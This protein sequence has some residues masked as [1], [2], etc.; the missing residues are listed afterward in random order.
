VMKIR[1]SLLVFTT[2]SLVLISSCTLEL[3]QETDPVVIAD[4]TDGPSNDLA[5]ISE[6]TIN[7]IPVDLG[8]IGISIDTRT[9][10]VF[11]YKPTKVNLVIE[12]ALGDYSQEGI[13]VDEY[14]NIAN[15]KLLR[16]DLSDEDFDEFSSGVPIIITVLDDTGAVIENKDV[17]RFIINSTARTIK[18][19][20]EKPRILRPLSF[21][22]AVPYYVQVVSDTELKFLSLTPEGGDQYYCPEPENYETKCIPGGTYGGGSYGSGTLDLYNRSVTVGRAFGFSEAQFYFEKTSTHD[23]DSS[24]YIKSK[25]TQAY[26]FTSEFN[27][28]DETYLEWTADNSIFLKTQ[29]ILEQTQNGTIKIR[30]LGSEQYLRDNEGDKRPTFSATSSNDLEFNIISANISWE[31]TD[32]GTKYSQPILPPV[33]MDFAFAQTIL[34]CSGATGDYEVGV[35]TVRETRTDISFGESLNLFS[36]ETSS[37]SATVKAEASGSLFGAGVTASVEGTLSTERTSTF[38]TTKERT[39]EEVFISKQ[40]V[41]IGRNITVPPYNAVEVFDVIQTLENIQI[42]FVQRIIIRGVVDEINL[43]GPEI[44]AQLIANGFGG[45][46]TEIGTDFLAVSVRGTIKVANYFE[47]NN[48]LNDI[49]GGCN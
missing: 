24:Y 34:N 20:T 31:F 26:L 22:A 21:N 15:F 14:T 46:I 29:F 9:L 12:G 43:T 33:E 2:I 6:E 19:T 13:N 16:K 23:Q 39:K 18:I 32:L 30:L 10:A 45:V 35:E 11:G 49:V 4:D 27:A 3:I 40:T 25:I 17:S 38:G 37:K 1:Y 28:P 47:F 42:P 44:E 41:S 36:S 7:E 5:G 48:S 8:E